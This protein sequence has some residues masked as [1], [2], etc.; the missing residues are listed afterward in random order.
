MPIAAIPVSI[1][2]TLSA[3]CS[4]TRAPPS[5]PPHTTTAPPLSSSPRSPPGT[6]PFLA[7]QHFI[8]SHTSDDFIEPSLDTKKKL[9]VDKLDLKEKA[10]L[11]EE[12]EQS[13]ASDIVRV[14]SL[15][16]KLEPILDETK[17]SK[18]KD[19]LEPIRNAKISTEVAS[20]LFKTKEEDTNSEVDYENYPDHYWETDF[21]VEEDL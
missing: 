14:D 11:E 6:P 12:T 16:T 17:D 9:E 18:L 1:N 3:H 10:A 21:E 5:T 2:S 4:P 8:P 20:Q 15:E 19:L 7:S 13:E